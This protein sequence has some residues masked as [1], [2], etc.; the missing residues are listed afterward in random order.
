MKSPCNSRSSLVHVGFALLLLSTTSAYSANIAQQKSNQL[1]SQPEPV[2]L[3]NDFDW[4]LVKEVFQHEQTN[5][6]FSPFSIKLLLTLLYE[7]SGKNSTTKRELSKAL[8]GSDLEKTRQLYREFLE[9]STKENRDYEFNIGT[10]IF[11]DQSITNVSDAYTELVESC[12]KTTVEPVLFR[13]STVTATKINDWCSEITQGHLNDLVTA[14]HIKDAT[15]IIANAL[16]LKASWKNSFTD[17][18]TRKRPFLISDSLTENVEFMEQT[19]IYEYLDDQD[20]QLEMLRLPYKGRHFS[21]Y[22]ILPYAN[23]TLEKVIDSLSA[24]NMFKLE[25]K[26]MRE[27]IVVIIPK[28]KFEFGI[29]LNDYLKSLGITEVFTR[30]ASLPQLSGGKRSNLE[31]SKI[32]QKA[33]IEVNERGTLAFAATEIQLVNKFGIDDSPIQFEANRPFMFYIKD[34]DSDAILFVGKVL[35]PVAS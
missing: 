1:Q 15:M 11:L 23:S 24:D 18:Y 10:R 30:R 28:F 22:L 25:D 29:T 4:N 19:N 8:S 2:P 34:E 32:L 17:E 3:S 12:Y 20:L 7:A 6:I 27:E 9:S 33:G 13:D 26:M 35:N 31:V 5:T 14:D 16:F 21:L